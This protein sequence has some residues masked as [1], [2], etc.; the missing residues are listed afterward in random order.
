MVLLAII[1]SARKIVIKDLVFKYKYFLLLLILPFIVFW[2]NILPVPGKVFFGNDAILSF[3]TLA[4]QVHQL[5]QGSLPLWDPH[6]FFGV[7]LMTR[8]DALVFYPPLGLL[9]FLSSVFKASDSVLYWLMEAVTVFHYSLAGLFTFFLLRKFKL[10]EFASFIGG[11]IYMFGGGIIAFA[12]TTGLQISMSYLPL[13]LLFFDNLIKKPNLKNSLLFSLVF[14][15]PVTTFAWTSTIVYHLI[16]FL[17]YFLFFLFRREAKLNRQTIIL[18]ALAFVLSALVS[19]VT[20]LPG[21]EVP[22]ISNRADITYHQSAFGGNLRPRQLFDFF[23][24]Y[25]TAS[26]YGEREII[27]VYFETWPYA[28]VGILTLLLLL[29]AF[30]KK[31]PLARLFLFLVVF[32]LLFALGGE[33]PIFS[34]VYLIF[35]PI[36]KPFSEARLSMYISQFS[37]AV[38]AALGIENLT[39]G[40]DEVRDR[41]LKYRG[42]LLNFLKLLLLVSLVIFFRID[43]A[44][45]TVVPTENTSVPMFSQL[46]VLVIFIILF[47]AST[48]TFF[49]WE[50]TKPANY[51]ILVFTILFLDLFLFAE[52]YPINNIGLDPAELLSKN[53]V[54]D[55]ITRESQGIFYRSDIR[56]LPHNYAPA[57]YGINHVSGY[58][59]YL[60]KVSHKFTP[61]ITTKPRNET[62]D[63]IAGI[64]YVVTDSEIDSPNYM[65][66]FEKKITEKDQKFYYHLGGGPPTGWVP[67]PIGSKIR[68]Y[69][70]PTHNPVFKIMEKVYFVNEIEAGNYIAGKLF[71][72]SQEALVDTDYREDLFFKEV[73]DLAEKDAT[74]SVQI[75][76]DKYADKRLLTRSPRNGLLVTSLP[77]NKDWSVEIDNLPQKILKVNLSFMGVALP[78]GSH[79][80]RF[81]YQPKA[82]R[83][84]LAISL[85]SLSVV[86]LTLVFVRRRPRLEKWVD[87]KP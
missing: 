5:N 1:A 75:L 23:I 29:P 71:N 6:T 45:W 7:P 22:L 83:A 85:V 76:S 62:A 3:Y 80:I 47:A 36:M 55:F 43:Q 18:A 57:L 24:P 4:S 16:L 73:S 69:E 68:V 49:L 9:V 31:S 25:L 21:L 61:L 13:E 66:V 27:K 77:F 46:N 65:L 8:P 79:Q 11:L 2:R 10:S 60:P 26:N 72:P 41:V 38:L 48:V 42:V 59:V 82:F 35:F 67:V 53:E 56:E 64:R 74:T 78:A 63:A 33:S 51:K 28:Y 30:F 84:G 50:R 15:L 52:K 58:L 54:V 34:L 12:N 70:N 87:K 32:W 17:F 86:I 14:A 44:L 39:V 19:A 81:Y 20:V 40:F 37:L